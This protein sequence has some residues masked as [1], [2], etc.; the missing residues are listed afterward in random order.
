MALPRAIRRLS[1]GSVR[2][3]PRLRGLA[4]RAGLARPRPVLSPA[5]TA[6]LAGLAR[7]RRRV[8]QIG[9]GEGESAVLLL[10]ALDPAAE[11][12]VVD[13]VRRSPDGARRRPAVD[14]RAARRVVERAARRAGG[15]A[16]EW[17]PGVS[18]AVTADW[19]RPVDLVLIDGDHSE[20]GVTTDWELW[21]RF[22]V[23]GGSV[24]FAEARASQPGGRGL[25]GP[26]AAVDRLF[27]GP[28]APHDWEISAEV[29]GALVVT[30]A[31]RAA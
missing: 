16:V 13:G 31:P 3:D 2:D 19:T 23:E 21:Q 30:H 18:A 15:P 7:R 8:V 17:H 12:H 26:T 25:P 1:A 29:D 27:R 14:G 28:R 24:M 10:T 4:L 22:V 20:I 11:L 9:V 6:L 5:E